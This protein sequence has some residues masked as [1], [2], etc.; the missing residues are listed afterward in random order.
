MLV[1]AGEF[2]SVGVMP[3]TMSADNV[4]AI[5]NLQAYDVREKV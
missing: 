5:R 2:A 3:I 1:S 4:E